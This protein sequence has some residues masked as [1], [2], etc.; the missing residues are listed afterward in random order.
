M[1]PLFLSTLISVDEHTPW[2]GEEK[3]T[4]LST[5]RLQETARSPLCA[6]ATRRAPDD[7]A[8]AARPPGGHRRRR[9]ERPPARASDPSPQTGRAAP[10]G[11]REA[12]GTWAGPAV[13]GRREPGI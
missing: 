9:G 4:L 1:T 8:D 3:A 2:W 12:M 6:P 10:T 5:R 11:A 13:A 7:P